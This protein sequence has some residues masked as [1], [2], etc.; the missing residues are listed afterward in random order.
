MHT[1]DLRWSPSR[2]QSE[3]RLRKFQKY[4]QK[5]RLVFWERGNGQQTNTCLFSFKAHLQKLHASSA[6]R[7]HL[8]QLLFWKGSLLLH[9][10]RNRLKYLEFWETSLLCM[11]TDVLGI[12]F[13]SVNDV[14]CSRTQ[15]SR[16]NVIV[17]EKFIFPQEGAKQV[18]PFHKFCELP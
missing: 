4:R 15:T 10:S 16:S 13:K 8:F 7:S 2:L 3:R 14:K 12:T 5:C 17:H 6:H 9:Q 18:L 11:Q 1:C